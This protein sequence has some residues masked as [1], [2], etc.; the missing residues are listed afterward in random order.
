MKQNINIR[1]LINEI[2]TKTVEKINVTE[3]W[4]FENINRIDKLSARLIKKRGQ[5]QINKIRNE[6]EVTNNPT[7]IQRILRDYHEQLYTNK[8]D[9]LEEMEKLIEMYNHP[10]LN[11]E[12]IKKTNIPNTSNETESVVSKFPTNKNPGP[13]GFTSGFY[14][15]FRVNTYPSQNIPKLQR[16]EHI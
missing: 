2:V 6:K 15:T 11:Q 5:A 16:K 3:S 13:D 9:N 14:Q 7:E 10:R 12:E 8:M 4:F 1:A